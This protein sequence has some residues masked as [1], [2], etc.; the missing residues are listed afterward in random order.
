MGKSF[1]SSY[2]SALNS[3]HRQETDKNW[4]EAHLEKKTNK[5]RCSCDTSITLNNNLNGAKKKSL[6]SYQKN[7]H[8]L[9]FDLE[10]FSCLNARCKCERNA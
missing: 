9:A 3:E 10:Q 7:N 8:R 4:S 1:S 2:T 6:N 5:Q